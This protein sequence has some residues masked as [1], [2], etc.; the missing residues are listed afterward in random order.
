MG[1]SGTILFPSV[2]KMICGTQLPVIIKRFEGAPCPTPEDGNIQF[3]KRHIVF[4]NSVM[5]TA[6]HHRQNPIES[7]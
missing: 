7:K 2:T 6:A 3:P 5:Q 4:K 1:Y